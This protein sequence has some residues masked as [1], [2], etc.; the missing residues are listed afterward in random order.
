MA[1][2][3]N[4]DAGPILAA[5]LLASCCAGPLLVAAAGGLVASAAGWVARYWP[6]VVAGVLVAAWATVR[7]ARTVRARSGRSARSSGRGVGRA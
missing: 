2:R 4:R 1:E 6:T 7:V 5:L 3:R